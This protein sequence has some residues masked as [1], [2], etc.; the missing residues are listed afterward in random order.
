MIMMLNILPRPRAHE[1]ELTAAYR[2]AQS[3]SL[4]S[5]PPSSTQ[6]TPRQVV[7]IAFFHAIAYKPS[8]VKSYLTTE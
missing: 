2:L 6:L 7:H 5:S 4:L 3:I 1:P 8:N